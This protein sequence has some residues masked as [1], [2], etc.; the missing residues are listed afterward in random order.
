[1]FDMSSNQIANHLIEQY[2]LNGARNAAMEYTA[3]AGDNYALSIWREVKNI[4]KEK[5]EPK[6]PVS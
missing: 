6:H 3:A 1:M 2:G 4:L 5:T